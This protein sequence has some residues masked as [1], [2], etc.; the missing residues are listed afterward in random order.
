[1]FRLS[2]ERLYDRESR[3]LANYERLVDSRDSPY[4]KRNIG[5][6]DDNDY[7][8]RSRS[9][10][11]PFSRTVNNN[12]YGDQLDNRFV[13]IYLSVSLALSVLSF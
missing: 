1:M 8:N 6:L 9:R 4:I 3:G 10:D 5:Y 11:R 13:S 7:Q 2:D 12:S